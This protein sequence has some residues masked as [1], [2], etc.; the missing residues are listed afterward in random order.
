MR[1]MSDTR[2]FSAE[3]GDYHYRRFLAWSFV[4]RQS[5]AAFLRN[6][7]VARTE[8][9]RSEIDDPL[10]HYAKLYSLPLEELLEAIYNAD[11][12]GVSVAQ[13]HQR[14]EAGIRGEALWDKKG[15]KSSE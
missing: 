14:L 15:R 2:I 9:N 10:D 4:E 5:K 7:A 1:I 12:N 13:L 8:A 6:L 11:R 3:F